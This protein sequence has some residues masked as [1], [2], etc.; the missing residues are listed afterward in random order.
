[1]CFQS[2][3][4]SSSYSDANCFYVFR[5]AIVAANYRSQIFKHFDTLKFHI[6]D[7]YIITTNCIFSHLKRFCFSSFITSPIIFSLF[8]VE[9]N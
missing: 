9:D 4:A 6:F 3:I 8:P 2:K 1:M 7:C 5:V